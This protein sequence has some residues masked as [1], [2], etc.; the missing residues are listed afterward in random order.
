MMHDVSQRIFHTIGMLI[1]GTPI[2][3]YG[4]ELGIKQV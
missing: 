1:G 4:D 2:V 3:L